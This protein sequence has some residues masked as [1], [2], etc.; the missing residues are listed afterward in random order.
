MQ[1][2]P[3]P[4]PVPPVA[5]RRFYVHTRTQHNNMLSKHLR[6]STS[7]Q[8]HTNTHSHPTPPPQ[9]SL[10][11]IHIMNAD[12]QLTHYGA[13]PTRLQFCPNCTHTLCAGRSNHHPHNHSKYFWAMDLVCPECKCLFTICMLC[14]NLRSHL[15]NQ[16]MLQRHHRQHHLNGPIH[17]PTP[18]PPTHLRGDSNSSISDLH[19]DSSSNTRHP[20]YNFL[21]AQASQQVKFSTS[22]STLYFQH[23][24]RD[25]NG[26][27]YLASQSIFHLDHTYTTLTQDDVSLNLL[28]GHL[29]I[30][31]PDKPRKMVC[32]IFNKILSR[33][34]A[35]P[36]NFDNNIASSLNTPRYHIS[37]LPSNFP[38]LRRQFL[39]GKFAMFP[40]LPMP[41][42]R[43]NGQ[44][45]Y[46]LPSDCLQ[47]YLS[48]GYKAAFLSSAPPPTYFSHVKHSPRAME[49]AADK[50]GCFA[51]AAF[52][53]SD[54]CDP[55]NS[56]KTEGSV[57]FDNKLC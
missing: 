4:D 40:C 50:N 3:F 22:F 43:T 52:L 16:R 15:I 20:N 17:P 23:Q 36:I 44:H 26:P 39:K 56:K 32:E 10:P 53:W 5:H 9:S 13:A 34:S 37:N 7:P 54:D 21:A 51:V 18:Q 14:R 45:A 55:Q 41:L 46:C 11:P 19:T 42:I 30:L 31:V 28:L 29:V 25:G 24:V 35:P 2:V 57:V 48:F 8:L 27:K 6:I 49:I 12:I 38:A 33:T 47:H 1:S